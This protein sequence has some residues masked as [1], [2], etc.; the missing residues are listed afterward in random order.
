VDKASEMVRPKCICYSQTS[1]NWGKRKYHM[2]QVALDQHIHQPGPETF[3]SKITLACQSMER[4]DTETNVEAI[5]RQHTA[6]QG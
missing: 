6:L 4:P 1:I 3:N 5:S 2:Q